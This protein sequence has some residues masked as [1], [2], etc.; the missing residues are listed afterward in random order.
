[1]QK[2]HNKITVC[3]RWL[4]EHE[5]EA[6]SPMQKFVHS[7]SFR[8]VISVAI[9]V[10][11]VTLGLMT[12]SHTQAVI[13]G[14]QANPAWD[15]LETC[16]GYIFL[17]ELLLR[18]AAE[19]LSFIVGANRRW[20]L[21]D[22]L[23]VATSLLDLVVASAP[24]V[25]VAR[26]LRIIR[27][28]RI[29]RAVRVLRSLQT[30][31]LMLVQ[32][33]ASLWNLVWLSVFLVFILY[34][35]ALFFMAGVTEA[36]PSANEE[37]QAAM[38]EY[39]GS[40]FETM[41]SLFMSVSG[42]HDWANRLQPFW[43][44]M[45]LYPLVFVLFIFAMLF[46][47]LN[48]VVAS[49][50]EAAAEASRHDR[51]AIIEHQITRARTIQAD[52]RRFFEEADADGNRSISL[53]ELRNHLKDDRI[54]AFFASLEIEVTQ[55]E[56]LFYLL[57]EDDSGNIG[58]QEFIAGC[59]RLRGTATSMDLNLLLWECEK[60]MCKFS[61]FALEIQSRFEWLEAKLGC[62]HMQMSG[63]MLPRKK[64]FRKQ[65]WTGSTKRPSIL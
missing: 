14:K 15:T 25:S 20:N 46:G 17:S 10:N 3:I 21:F 56:D 41:L 18:F 44:A 27:F 51:D 60:L 31:R 47:M 58:F 13:A 19:R 6:N 54:K 5:P 52:I 37:M 40:V 32:M 65:V 38:H 1:M 35:A 61:D 30:F 57:D 22:T 11:A 50:C 62:P 34:S 7:T 59:M 9:V 53:A 49:F 16:F 28:I 36:Y 43:S 8:V 26:I 4:Q 24:N 64:K 39:Y 23:I 29:L 42:G 33:L 2:I 12:Q 48:I 45:P 55:A 63:P